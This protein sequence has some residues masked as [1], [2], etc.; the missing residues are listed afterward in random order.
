MRKLVTLGVSGLLAGPAAAA[1]MS[2]TIEIPALDVAEYH[3]PY[4]ATW[5]EDKDGAVAANL[6]VWYH[7]KKKD[8]KG[9]KWLKDMRLWW[10]RTGRD[11]AMPVD[12]LSSAT[13]PPGKHTSDYASGEAPLA[14]LK[15]GSYELVVEAAREVG[16]REVLRIPFQWPPASPVNATARGSAELGEIALKI[17]P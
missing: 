6:S 17:E 11:L 7:L 12:G 3:R 9:N 10:R 13:R 15:P 16:G 14:Q 2:V 8:N 4:V 1:D 5:I